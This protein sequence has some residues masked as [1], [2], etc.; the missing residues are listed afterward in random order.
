MS[1]CRFRQRS[2]SNKGLP[3]SVSPGEKGTV[4][5]NNPI[6]WRDEGLCFIQKQCSNPT[7]C[8]LHLC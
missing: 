3:F 2:E 8:Q 6:Y 4:G 5:A 7:R 1:D